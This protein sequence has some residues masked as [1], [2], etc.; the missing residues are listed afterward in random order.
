MATRNKRTYEEAGYPYGIKD[1]RDFVEAFGLVR[2]LVP[3]EPWGDTFDQYRRLREYVEG[4]PRTSSTFTTKALCKSIDV[5]NRDAHRRVVA[6]LRGLGSW[7]VSPEKEW[8][9]VFANP[10][11]MHMETLEHLQ[12]RDRRVQF[13]AQAARYGRLGVD[14]IATAWGVEKGS[15]HT[16]L[17]RYGV[18]FRD[19]RARGARHIVRTV[20]LA[21]D[22]LG[23]S[24]R[25]LLED[26]GLSKATFDTWRDRYGVAFEDR[27]VPPDPFDVYDTFP[28]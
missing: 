26:L 8:T 27:E 11:Y 10:G 3:F 1:V 9:K 4:Q 28:H 19:E 7:R 12:D 20:T 13:A 5:S 15:A 22:W 21:S 23:R 14:G 6:H 17:D 24:Q 16:L 2:G 25:E 18:N